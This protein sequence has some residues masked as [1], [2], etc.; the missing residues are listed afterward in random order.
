MGN[1]VRNDIEMRLSVLYSLIGQRP[2]GDHS[3]EGVGFLKFDAKKHR[4]SSHSV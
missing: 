4:I 3:M 1:K 2:I